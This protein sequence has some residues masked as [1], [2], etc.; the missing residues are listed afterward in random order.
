M[1]RECPCGDSPAADL[2]RFLG[3]LEVGVG[4]GR[5]IGAVDHSADLG[6]GSL[7]RHLDPL[8][9]R[10]IDLGTSLTTATELDVSRAIA[11][12]EQIHK[13]TVRGDPW[14][15]L[16]VEN[17]LDPRRDRVAPAFIRIVD[18]QRAPDRRVVEVDDGALQVHGTLRVHQHGQPRSLD[19]DVVGDGARGVNEVDL[20]NEATAPAPAYFQPEARVGPPALPADAVY[21]FE[22]RGRQSQLKGHRLIL[23]VVR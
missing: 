19:D 10:Y 15:Y 9:E 21:L 4:T 13:A 14:I 1:V 22:R 20:I 16:S 23:L 3:R 2:G 17:I 11:D 8:P 7:D 5:V 18:G 6:N 12:I